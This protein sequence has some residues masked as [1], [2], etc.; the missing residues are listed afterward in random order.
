MKINTRYHEEIEVNEEDKIYFDRGIPGFPQENEFVILPLGTNSPFSVL[1][2]VNNEELGF[3]VA[4]PFSFYK[5]YVFDI[6]ESVI[7]QLSIQD[8]TDI[9]I[10]SIITLE[11]SLSTSTI[12]LQAPVII[13]RKK[14]KGKQA[15]LNTEIYH[16]KHRLTNKN[17][18]IG[19][20]G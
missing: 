3:V 11:D 8:K 12:N 10:Y 4:E 2:S 1:Q 19:Q 16:T 17:R 20:E 14:N 6:E 5:E 9:Q 7:S 18:Q 13:N 15:I